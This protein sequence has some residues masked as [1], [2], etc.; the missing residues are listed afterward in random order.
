MPRP[1]LLITSALWRAQV[2]HLLLFVV[3]PA[4]AAAARTVLGV[5]LL[6]LLLVGPGDRTVSLADGVAHL[7][8]AG[9][10]IALAPCSLA[11]RVL[12]QPRSASADSPSP[13]ATAAAAVEVEPL[14]PLPT[15]FTLRHAW[16]GL[17]LLWFLVFLV[18]RERRGR[19]G[20]ERPRG[21][22]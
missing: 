18:R 10:W 5:A 16:F 12:H 20:R 17:W 21:G 13:G 15:A 14:L 9:C 7:A 11:D 3:L 1:L 6:P 2:V 4:M 19:R 8:E 22:G